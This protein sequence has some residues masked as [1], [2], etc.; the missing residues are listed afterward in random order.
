MTQ[1]P[2]APFNLGPDNWTDFDTRTDACALQR[3]IA[4]TREEGDTDH[5]EMLR[6]RFKYL[7][8]T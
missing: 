3:A 7:R 4:A 5:Q 2:N 6:S 1:D 8:R